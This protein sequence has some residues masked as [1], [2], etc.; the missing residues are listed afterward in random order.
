MSEDEETNNKEETPE[1]N[2]EDEPKPKRD[3]TKR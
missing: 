3:H 2:G 1:E